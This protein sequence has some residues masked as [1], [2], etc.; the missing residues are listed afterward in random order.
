MTISAIAEVNLGTMGREAPPAIAV[1][2]GPFPAAAVAG[3]A[4]PAERSDSDAVMM[5]VG[6]IPVVTG[7]DSST[8]VVG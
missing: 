4:I 2:E 8:V 1:E 3:S 7:V 5:A 6:S